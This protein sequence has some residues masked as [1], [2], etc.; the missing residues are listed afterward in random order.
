[1]KKFWFALFILLLSSCNKAEWMPTPPQM[2]PVST[3]TFDRLAPPPMPENPS[4]ADLG[5]KVYYGV[6]MAC[7]G[8]HGQGL[9]EEWRATRGEDSNCWQSG[10]HG[11]DHP[12]EGFL[13]NK[14]CCTAV[15][16]Q[17]TLIRFRNGQDLFEYVSVYMP[18]WKPGYLKTEEYWQVTAYLL[19]VHNALPKGVTVDKTNA[20]IFNVHPSGSMP[21]NGLIFGLIVSVLLLL[22]AFILLWQAR[23]NKGY[24]RPKNP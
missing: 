17:G 4:Q 23:I 22:I 13:I 20:Y 8:D 2:P 14:T 19:H 15:M 10:C 16:G 11:S 24:H 7:H 9:T 5:A 12:P 6:C 21:E 3:P 18:W 1:M